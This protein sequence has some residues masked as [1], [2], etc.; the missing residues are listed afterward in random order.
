MRGRESAVVYL[1]QRR[2]WRTSSASRNRRFSCSPRAQII[3][4]VIPRGRQGLVA[5]RGTSEGLAS[6]LRSQ[7]LDASSGGSKRHLDA[8]GAPTWPAFDESWWYRTAFS[9]TCRSRFSRLTNPEESYSS[10][11]FE[12]SYLPSASSIVDPAAIRT[13]PAELLAMAPARSRLAHA[14]REVTQIMRFHERHR[15]LIGPA[16]TETAFKQSAR[17]FAVVHLATHGFF[18][19]ANP[20]FSGIDLEGSAE[21]D[22][23]LEVH[24]ILRMRLRASL[25]TLSAC[26]DGAGRRTVIGCA[27]R[28]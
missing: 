17:N 11:G 4:R 15:A 24:E 23:R 22:G 26:R 8:C 9:I 10:T 28:G 18:N 16:A 2:W 14:A 19:Q 13:G 3:A 27:P 6:S 7:C 25:V 20:L 1:S 12:I 5:T 21:D